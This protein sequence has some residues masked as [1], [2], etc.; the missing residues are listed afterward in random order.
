MELNTA[1]NSTMDEIKVK[2][3]Q[4]LSNISVDINKLQR[5]LRALDN[6]ADGPVD[7][8]RYERLLDILKIYTESGP[9]T[10]QVLINQ[11][12]LSYVMVLI[13]IP[14]STNT[15]RKHYKILSSD[16][17]LLLFVLLGISVLPNKV[18]V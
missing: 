12:F 11:G 17:F 18:T 8:T 6:S 4:D 16:W 10:L 5:R 14:Q 2:S 3:E 7:D 13:L 9:E 15:F 1:Q